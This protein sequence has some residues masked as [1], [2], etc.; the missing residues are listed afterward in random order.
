MIQSSTNLAPASPTDPGMHLVNYLDLQFIPSRQPCGAFRLDI[1]LY[2]KRLE[3]K[4]VCM[5]LQQY[6]HATGAL[7]SLCKLNIIVSRYSHNHVLGPGV[8]GFSGWIPVCLAL[9]GCLRDDSGYL[10]LY[11]YRVI[12]I[13]EYLCWQLA[14]MMFDFYRRGYRMLPLWKRLE[15]CLRWQPAFKPTQ[16][17]KLYMTE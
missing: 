7:S 15:R 3:A 14:R 16:W 9:F 8:L 13:Q 10:L 4:F 11:M 1:K 5:M 6:L 17:F 12:T 2:D